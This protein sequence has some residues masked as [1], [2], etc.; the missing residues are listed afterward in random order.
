MAFVD[1]A[2]FSALTE[3]HGDHDAVAVVDRFAELSRAALSSGDELVKS[4][5]DAARF[6]SPDPAAAVA[7]LQRVWRACAAECWFPLPRAGVHR[8]N[9]I[10]RGGD[11]FGRAVNLSARVAGHAGGASFSPPAK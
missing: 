11:Y 1:L 4:V 5:G 2:G 7:L 6:A 8:G 10:A 3:A 9:A